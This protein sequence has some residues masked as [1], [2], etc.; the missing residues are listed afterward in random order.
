M[1]SKKDVAKN[2]WEKSDNE[3]IKLENQGL[4]S[5]SHYLTAPKCY[6][7]S[8]NKNHPKKNIESFLKMN[9]KIHDIWKNDHSFKNDQAS[10]KESEDSR[11]L[12]I[13]SSCYSY[14][15]STCS[16]CSNNT[17]LINNLQL[18]IEILTKK[19]DELNLNSDKNS[20][21]SSLKSKE[22]ESYKSKDQYKSE[23]NHKNDYNYNSNA[24]KN[25]AK[26]GQLNKKLDDLK[27]DK[28][29]KTDST[30]QKFNDKK[31]FEQ[32]DNNTSRKEVIK[33]KSYDSKPKKSKSFVKN[34]SLNNERVNNRFTKDKNSLKK[35]NCSKKIILSN[36]SWHNV[37]P[38]FY[39]KL[40]YMTIG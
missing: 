35:P 9:N 37:A 7:L 15:N 1:I 36:I 16:S 38:N 32:K 11:A 18:S 4:L 22:K 19:V 31:I 25:K 30:K 23:K 5:D 28:F 17:K 27:N 29:K 33:E 6:K 40:F 39:G 26:K 2:V 21:L 3:Q 14:N 13:N 24:W 20:S 34:D 12:D 8:S 10:T